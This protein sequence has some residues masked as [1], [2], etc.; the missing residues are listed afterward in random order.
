MAPKQRGRNFIKK[1]VDSLLDFVENV[2]PLG[3]FDWERVATRYNGGERAETHRTGEALKDKFRRLKNGEGT[4]GVD[5]VKELQKDLENEAGVGESPMTLE[6]NVAILTRL[7][8]AVSAVKKQFMRMNPLVTDVTLLS[9]SE[10]S[11]VVKTVASRSGAKKTVFDARV[12]QLHVANV[13]EEEKTSILMK[14]T[15]C[16][17]VDTVSKDISIPF[18][19]ELL[20]DEENKPLMWKKRAEKSSVRMRK[21]Q[22]IGALKQKHERKNSRSSQHQIQ[23]NVQNAYANTFHP[24]EALMCW[25]VAA[26]KHLC[27]CRRATRQRL[28]FK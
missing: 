28:V 22:S 20:K 18:Y 2:K 13:Q 3:Q 7:Q 15:I 26:H 14:L 17:L 9:I 23:S 6:G 12:L 5:R 8:N 10:G 25:I 24:Q 27:G 19:A 16:G 4:Y 11:D 1:E 21:C